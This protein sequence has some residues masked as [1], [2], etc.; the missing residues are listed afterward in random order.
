[1]SE[2]NIFNSL[3][4]DYNGADF[5]VLVDGRLKTISLPRPDGCSPSEWCAFWERVHELYDSED[6]SEIAALENDLKDYEYDI[7]ELREENRELQREL[8]VR[9]RE[10]DSLESEIERLR[11]ELEE[12]YRQ[13]S[14]DE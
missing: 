2:Y 13:A 5:E 11:E 4:T 14:E 10:I 7:E 1:M 6:K 9:D 8:D 3:W 12:A